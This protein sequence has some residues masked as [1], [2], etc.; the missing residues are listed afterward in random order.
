M[1]L[2]KAVVKGRV[3]ILVVA[4]LLLIPSVFGMI[5]TRVN[6]DMLNYLPDTLDT[7]KGQKYML[8]DFGKGAFSFLIFEDMDDRQISAVADEI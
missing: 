4:L 2:G 8:E 3:L 7:V 6:Y 1:K 5:F